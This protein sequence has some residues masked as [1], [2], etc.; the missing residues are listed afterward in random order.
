MSINNFSKQIGVQNAKLIYD[1]F[2]TFT[3]GVPNFY[4]FFMGGVQMPPN[5]GKNISSGGNNFFEDANVLSTTN[6]YRTL[7]KK[8]IALVVRRIDWTR[9]TAYHPYRSAGQELDSESFYAYNKTNRTVY[10]CVSDNEHNRYDLRAQS[11]SSVAPS[12]SVGI[13][14]YEDGYSWLPL[15][16]IDWNLQ[17]FLTGTWLPVPSLDGFS[18]TSKS[19]TFDS[20]S[21]EK[22]GVNYNT[23]G[24]CCL[25]HSS[26][27]YDSVG[28]IYHSPGDI[29][30]SFSNTKCYECFE[31]SGRL[32]ME[33]TFTE[34][35]TGTNSCFSCSETS[36]CACTKAVSTTAEKI[37]ASKIPSINN[38]KFQTK[39]EEE[40]S[41]NDGRI[42]SVF[43]DMKNI[44]TSDLIVSEDH[45]Q[46]SIESST[47]TGAVLRFKTHKDAYKNIVIHG[48]EVVS[49]GSGYKDIKITSAQGFESKI[50]IN[51]DKVDGVA[52]N[53]V[54]LLGACNIMYNIQ[55][56]SSEIA[57]SAGT[58]QRNFKFYGISKNVEIKTSGDIKILGSDIQEKAA[59]IFHRATDKYDISSLAMN[60]TSFIEADTARFD[61][62]TNESVGQMQTISFTDTEL[63]VFVNPTTILSDRENSTG[64]INT[65]DTDVVYTITDRNL[66]NIVHGSGKVVYTK[67]NN[68]I[69]LPS[70]GQPTQLLTFRIIKSYC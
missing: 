62:N 1:T 31:L 18:E 8:N 65:N 39:T 58:N 4:S 61:N 47:G 12:H 23:C 30:K 46:I 22:C 38:E 50:E 68:V 63:E 19:G 16:K 53:P 21:R 3:N 15:Y 49:A 25:Y 11:G 6:F 20:S 13:Q 59:P 28:S 67:T 48:V 45:P 42:M 44:P 60:E 17:P 55:I 24:T 36:P 35:S 54:E 9:G 7:N 27:F 40:S 56:R 57:D 66:S 43:F 34:S 32:G 29:Y 52:V 33:M 64:I 51:I 14:K 70:D 69:N 26:Y 41:S 5:V 2:G 10:L 37:K